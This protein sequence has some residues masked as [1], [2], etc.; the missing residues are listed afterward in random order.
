MNDDFSKQPKPGRAD[1]APEEW[2]SMYTIQ[3][4]FR[5]KPGTLKYWRSRKKVRFKIEDNCSYY[6]KS[7][8]RAL[9]KARENSKKY[10]GFRKI[11]EKKFLRINPVLSMTITC[12][13]LGLIY[14]RPFRNKPVYS[15]KEVYLPIFCLLFIA[16]VYWLIIII[17]SKRKK[18]LKK[19]LEE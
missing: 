9:V 1:S 18:S 2:T 11:Y 16:L 7:E 10:Y 13:I 6:I 14:I 3:E 15:A 12:V 19:K 5:V 4:L 8:I 17:W